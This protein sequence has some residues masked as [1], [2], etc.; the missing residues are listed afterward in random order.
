VKFSLRSSEIAA[1]AG[2]FIFTFCVSKM[3]HPKL[4]LDFIVSARERFHQNL[5]QDRFEPPKQKQ[6]ADLA[7]IF[8]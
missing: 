5:R 7:I 4:V 8:C 6:M 1:A 2:G 3:F